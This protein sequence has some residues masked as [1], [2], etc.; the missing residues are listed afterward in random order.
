MIDE[1]LS[2][3]VKANREHL[4]LVQDC[5]LDC[6]NCLPVMKIHCWYSNIVSIANQFPKDFLEIL[7][8]FSKKGISFLLPRLGCN[9]VEELKAKLSEIKVDKPALAEEVTH[10]GS[11][12]VPCEVWHSQ[13]FAYLSSLAKVVLLELLFGQRGVDEICRRHGITVPVLHEVLDSLKNYLVLKS[14]K[15]NDGDLSVEFVTDWEKS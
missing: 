2:K 11:Y 15:T 7:P 6:G 10:S 8:Y 9:T 5:S 4:L 1:L 13:R 3:Y 12:S 14:W